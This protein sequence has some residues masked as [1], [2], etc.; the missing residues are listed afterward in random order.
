M[1]KELKGTLIGLIVSTLFFL[2]GQT[3]IIPMIL[4]SPVVSYFERRNTD[5]PYSVIGENAILTLSILSVIIFFGCL[6]ATYLNKR[7]TEKFPTAVLKVTFILITVF[8]HPLGF[9]IHISSNWNMASDG[10]FVFAMGAAFPLT[11][12]IYILIGMFSDLI[13][14][15]VK[16]KPIKDANLITPIKSALHNEEPKLGKEHIENF[17]RKYRSYSTK[18]LKE[19]INEKGWQ[20]EAKE[21]AKIIL[22]EQNNIT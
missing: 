6:L 21:A 8:I 4:V 10:Q 1:R 19:I 17:K 12:L 9:F 14:F 7:K 3:L 16:S 20:L 22:E 2:I 15:L 18:Q 11:S 5:E 13:R